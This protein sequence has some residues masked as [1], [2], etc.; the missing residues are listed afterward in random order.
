L[1]YFTCFA[2]TS[3]SNGQF[4]LDPTDDIFKLDS[5]VVVDSI[6]MQEDNFEFGSSIFDCGM[7][8]VCILK[9]RKLK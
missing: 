6:Q 4:E 7:R 2:T 1:T 5:K 9:I 8:M 3:I